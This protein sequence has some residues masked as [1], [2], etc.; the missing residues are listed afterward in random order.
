MVIGSSGSEVLGCGLFGCSEL[1]GG[2]WLVKL[3]GGGLGYGML[4]LIVVGV[5]NG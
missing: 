2:W 1:G 4:W 5:E 3:C